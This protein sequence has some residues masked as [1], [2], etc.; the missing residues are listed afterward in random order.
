MAFTRKSMDVWIREALADSDKDG[1]CTM[2][3]LVHMVGIQQKEI[4]TTK[5]SGGRSWTEQDLATMFRGKAETYAQDIPG[6][7]SFQLLAFYGERSSA[8][9]FF[10]FIINI[11]TDFGG[12]STEAPTDTGRLQQI[13]R[14]EEMLIGQVYRRQ[15]VMDDFTIRMMAQMGNTIETLTRE[16]RDAFD[17][18][19]EMLMTRA[20]DDHNRKMQ[21]LQFE[22]DSGERKKWMSWVPALANTILGREI[23]PQST[24]DTSLVESIA[25]ALTEQDIVKLAGSMK[26]ELWGPLAARMQSYMQK[27]NE[28][29]RNLKQ[30][31]EM[32]SSDPEADAAGEVVSITKKKK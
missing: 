17:I 12:L 28:E 9:A 7:Q 25:D 16:N 5:F 13:M 30:L 32:S 8:E 3:A 24:A 15:Q 31:S 22:R 18:V 23:F 19:K 26:P 21:Q 29:E 10:P 20:L 14:R 2:L 6:V 11:A 1:K 4:H 27:K